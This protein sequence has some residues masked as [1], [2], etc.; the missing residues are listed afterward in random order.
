[1][2]DRLREA[3]RR[4]IAAHNRLV[5]LS[6]IC[7]VFAV[8]AMWVFLYFAVQW[9]LA[10]SATVV[11][12]VDAVMPGDFRRTFA[13]FAVALLSAGWLA[14]RFG[15]YRR[16]REDRSAGLVMLELLLLPA[17]ATFASLSNVRNHIR[18]S[19]D[20]LQAATD[21]L[22]RIVR[23]GKLRATAVPVEIPGDSSRERVLFALQLLELIYLRQGAPADF[24]AVADPQQL[25][26]FL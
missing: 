5:A 21:L 6:S 22:V 8:A 4:K 2:N 15:L 18:L 1:M 3:L 19:E 17:R 9:A 16:L 13:I 24:Y 25:L 14:R 10:M 12:G 7:S 20:D 26:R 23:A 11:K